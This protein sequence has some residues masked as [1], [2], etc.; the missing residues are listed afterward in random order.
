MNKWLVMLVDKKVAAMRVKGEFADG[1]L[2]IG[3]FTEAEANRIVA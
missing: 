1:I 2:F 3:K